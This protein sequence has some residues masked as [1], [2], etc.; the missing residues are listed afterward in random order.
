MRPSQPPIRL[1][2]EVLS[3]GIKWLNNE[4]HATLPSAKFKNAWNCTSTSPY[5]FI[6]GAYLIIGTTLFYVSTIYAVCKV[7]TKYK[8]FN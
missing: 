5:A 3:S 8:A 4:A 6:V 1:V 2:E 7:Y